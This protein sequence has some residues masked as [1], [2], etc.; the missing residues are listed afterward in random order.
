MIE[1]QE[2]TDQVQ[3]LLSDFNTRLR[4]LDERNKLI[5]ERVLLLGGNLI[6]S[7]Q[8]LENELTEIKKENL[9]IKENL[10]KIKKVSNS[11]LSEFNKFVKK[12]EIIL[13]E[14]MLKD[15]QPL[16]FMRKKD[17]EELIE[18]K[19]SKKETNKYS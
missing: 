13:I 5:R 7:R 12:D 3:F 14:R 15:F 10:S 17:V 1:Q 16:E 11:L 2:N 6:S 4:D 18:D 9:E 19:L 8:E